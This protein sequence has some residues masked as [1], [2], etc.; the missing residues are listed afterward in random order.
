LSSSGTNGSSSR[1]RTRADTALADA[2]RA[3]AEKFGAEIVESRVFEDTGGARSTDSGLAQVRQQVPLFTQRA[4]EH[5]ILVAAD[6]TEVFS[7]H[8]PYHTWD[9]RPVA[10][11]A[12][13]TPTTWHPAHESWGATQ[14]QARFERLANRPM[15]P[16]D[17]NI[18]MALR[19]LG[20]A[21]TRTNAT[22]PETIRGYIL[23]P[24]F[25]L[26]GFKGQPLSFRD[27]DHQLRQPILLAADDVVVAVSPQEEFLHQFSPLDS[28]GTDRPETACDL[29]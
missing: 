22:D 25:E 9:A 15:R 7:A 1:A 12:G 4:P 18:W 27:W 11:S 6:E 29:S 23:G 20:E 21:A 8:L 24:E 28:L 16:V 19:V 3:A 2:Y 10:G 26:A 17:Y 5:E 14:L 13:L